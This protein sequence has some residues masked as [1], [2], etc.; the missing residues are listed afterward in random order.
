MVKEVWGTNAL[1]EW[2]PPKDDGNTEI[3]GYFVQKADKKTMVRDQRGQGRGGPGGRKPPR[4]SEGACCSH[5]PAGE[6]EVGEWAGA[7][8][9]AFWL[10][11]GA[12]QS[13]FFS[14]QKK[15]ISGR[16]HH[17]SVVHKPS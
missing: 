6:T 16:S 8:R 17:G 9:E 7:G 15:K 3:T 11:L 12:E 1:V 14:F 13:I 2:Q 5:F 4:L 10:R